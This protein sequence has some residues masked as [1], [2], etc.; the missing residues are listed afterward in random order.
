MEFL[1]PTTWA[2]ALAAKAATPDAVPIAGGTDV[3][4]ELNFARRRPAALLDLTR[5]PELAG[6]RI[7][8]G[9]LRVGAG[10]TYAELTGERARGGRPRGPDR[11]PEGLGRPSEGLGRLSEGLGRLSEGL[12]R[13]LPG[14]AIA[15][16]TVGSP[17]IRNSGTIGGNLGSASPA[18]DCHPCLLAAGAQVEVASVRGTRLIPVDEFFTG[19]KRNALAP[20]ELIAAVWVGAPSGPEQFAKIGTR[21]AMVIAVAAFGL[22]LHPD[23]RAVGTGVGSAAP[24]PVRAGQ[25]EAF[26]AAALDESGLWESR[27]ELPEPVV[28][29]FGAL[30]SAAAQPID[31]VRGTAAYRRHALGGPAVR[32]ALR[33]RAGLRQLAGLAGK[34]RAR[35]PGN[36]D[37]QRRAAPGRRRLA[38]REPAVRAPRA[39]GPARL[40]ECLRAGRVRVLHGL[41][42]RRPGLRV[43]GRGRPGGG[44]R[45]R[46]RRGPGRRG[47]RVAPGA[48]GVRRGGSRP[49][50]VLY[51]RTA[52]RRA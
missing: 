15:A 38:G 48:A 37:S 14:L 41:P 7:D 31:D 30:V 21:N 50:R 32:A 29:E 52:G 39:D 36:G 43:P 51:P 22:A 16:R 34:G 10:V 47:R 4:V 1:Q 23:R 9:L 25:A 12:G 11:R 35:D 46:D 13:R 8:G 17:Q 5:V 20:D 45:D 49:V 33:L 42:G 26:L 18:G 40:E 27:G 2:E 6:W 28:T 24:T 44:P 3:M 19:V